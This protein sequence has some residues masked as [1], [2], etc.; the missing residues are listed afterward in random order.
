MY[1][2]GLSQF[3]STNLPEKVI[4]VLLKVATF[5]TKSYPELLNNVLYKRWIKNSNAVD[6]LDIP[7][8][9]EAYY[10]LITGSV[11]A[12][13]VLPALA[14]KSLVVL[15]SFITILIILYHVFRY[16]NYLR[17]FNFGSEVSKL[18]TFYIF[19]IVPFKNTS[20]LCS[21]RNI[22]A[23]F[24]SEYSIQHFL[25]IDELIFCMCYVLF[26]L[27]FSFIIS[28][29]NRYK[30]SYCILEF[31]KS[32]LKKLKIGFAIAIFFL[33]SLNMMLSIEDI[34]LMVGAMLSAFI[35]FCSLIKYLRKG[36]DHISSETFNDILESI[37]SC[38]FPFIESL[39][40]I[41]YTITLI[42]FIYRD[43][44]PG[45]NFQKSICYA[46]D[47]LFYN[48]FDQKPTF[49][50]ILLKIGILGLFIFY[51]YQEKQRQK[52]IDEFIKEKSTTLETHI[53]VDP[54][55]M[56]LTGITGEGLA[57]D[58]ICK[59]EGKKDGNSVII[60]YPP[61]ILL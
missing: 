17:W 40:H 37:D 54:I 19:L 53:S 16:F 6:I 57:R 9:Q 28:I 59:E 14:Y 38:I 18:T 33:Y 1:F 21:I 48:I 47:F 4:D 50:S 13:D 26:Y 60:S 30:W 27:S 36:K 22:F 52:S 32:V 15:F 8:T 25:I 46:L 20:F 12:D 41:L 61:N 42:Q 5:V 7:F 39:I 29:R 56:E 24:L 3:N 35:V 34:C 43:L 55:N 23:E 49:F 45:S 58:R 44:N 11:I 51:C 2:E 31:V 10:N